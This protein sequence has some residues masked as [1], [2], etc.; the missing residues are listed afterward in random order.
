MRP[1]RVLVL[2]RGINVGGRHP[3]PMPGLRALFAEL[4]CTDIDTYIQSGNL[5]C[6]AHPSLSATTISAAVAE[7][8]GFPVPVTLRTAQ[9]LNAS[10]QAN[11]F[12]QAGVD[13][14][15]A[16]FFE[17]PL[18]AAALK[19]LEAKCLGQ[20]KLSAIGRELFLYLPHG[21]G[22][23]RLALACTAPALPGNPTVRNWKTIL[24]LQRLL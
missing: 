21:F 4:G 1:Q 8:F 15:H 24:Q 14:L 16:V 3:L 5:V 23:S 17:A 22:R 13:T 11:P 7:R 19:T 10:I 20:E 18:P 9:E 2:L 6:S 12:A